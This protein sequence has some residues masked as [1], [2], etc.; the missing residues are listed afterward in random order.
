MEFSEKINLIMNELGADNVSIA[1]YGGFDRTSLSRFRNGKR[2]PGASSRTGGM[3]VEGIYLYADNGNS[4]EKLCSIT[5]GNPDGSA[6]EIKDSVSAWLYDGMQKASPWKRP[7]RKALT[8]NAFGERLDAVMSIAGISNIR[9]SR[10]MNVDSSLISRYR[11]GVRTPRSNPKLSEKLSDV[12]WHH[13]QNPQKKEDLAAVMECNAAELDRDI[14]FGWLC[15]FA[16]M[17]QGNLADVEKIIAA[18]DMHLSASGIPTVVSDGQPQVSADEREIYIGTEGLKEAVIRFLNNVALS[19]VQEILLYSDENMDWLTADPDFRMQWMRLMASCAKSGIRIRIIHNID[20]GFDEMS[21]AIISW[22]PLYMTGMIESFYCKKPGGSRFT[23]SLYI[24][25]GHSAIEAFHVSGTEGSGIYH[26]HTEKETLDIL[27]SEYE[28]LLS[29]SSPLISVAPPMSGIK[30]GDRQISVRNTLSAVTMSEELADSFGSEEFKAM[31]RLRRDV[32]EG[33]LKDGYVY[34]CVPLAPVETVLSGGVPVQ[35][36]S[37]GERL[38]Y[39]PEQYKAHIRL[40]IDLLNRFPSYR[41]YMLEDTPFHNMTIVT[42]TGFVKVA[43]VLQP[44]FSIMMT[45]PAICRAF[46]DYIDDLRALATIDRHTLRE[47]LSEYLAKLSAE[48]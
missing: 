34:E 23:H 8:L 37:G 28:K 45:H 11:S 19:E 5:G 31:W 44:E 43:S 29:V 15:D 39:S 13:L 25:P 22:L 1:R 16:P 2:M 10:L 7:E 47:Q 3:L 38:T 35:A 9:L 27:S 21:D 32:F 24:C 33:C 4:L 26:Y 30:E 18:F 17:Q 46:R 41:F 14:F 12:L 20:R 40:I 36:L 6:E 48:A 42:G